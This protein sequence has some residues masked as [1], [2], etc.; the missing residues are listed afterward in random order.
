MT[1]KNQIIVLGNTNAGKSTFLNNLLDL[2]TLLNTSEFRETSTLW[3]LKF[4][5][6]LN[7][8]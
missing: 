8:Q 5:P 7:E 1:I 6:N 3:V 2:G 4:E